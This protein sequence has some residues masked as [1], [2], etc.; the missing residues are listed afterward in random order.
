MS[1]RPRWW[2]TL[3]ASKKEACLAVDLYNRSS[4]E[5]SLEGFVVHTHTAWLYML[6]ARFERDRVDFRYWHRH[7]LVRVD[8]EPKT[9]DL[10]RGLV[11]AYPDPNDPV[12]RNVEFF[13][14][15]RNKIEHRYAELI[16]V[17]VAGKTQAH[18]LNYED[19]LTETF[20][21]SEGLGDVLRFPVFVSSLTPDAVKALGRAHR[22]LPKR[23][24]TFIRNYD[25]AL[26]DEVKDDYRY[27]FRILLLPKTGP[28][29]D[30]DAVV[31]FVREDELSDMQR[32]VV[33]TITREKL[34][35]VQN[36][37]KYTPGAVA[38]KGRSGSRGEVR[39]LVPSC[40]RVEIL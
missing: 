27:D 23:L 1:R 21:A 26:P 36:K 17:A 32:D 22:K 3:Q 15:L 25:A 12:R 19:A 7:R 40:A 14:Q 10:A 2:F 11:E 35:P 39:R 16:A 29:T 9:W 37:G 30:A 33:E 34:V 13:I 4:A 38:K 20:G 18:V 5:R 24:T 31:R 6:H 28:K 8:G